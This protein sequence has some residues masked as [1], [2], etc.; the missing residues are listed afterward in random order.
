MQN[1]KA[2]ENQGQISEWNMS[3]SH[4]ILRELREVTPQSLNHINLHIS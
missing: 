2:G 3:R 4:R 1:S